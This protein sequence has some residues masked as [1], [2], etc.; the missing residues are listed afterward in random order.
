MKQHPFLRA[1]LA[2]I[3]VPTVFVLVAFSV[4]CVARFVYQVP[5]PI[6]RVIVFPLALIPNA[7]GAWNMLFVALH[8]RRY[9]P[10]GIHGALLPFIIAPTG[11]LIA[12]SL[13]FLATSE[14][15]LVWFGTI[16]IDYSHLAI[17]FPTVLVVYYLVWK[18]LVGFLNELLGVA[19]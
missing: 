16:R 14:Q 15:G 11:F 4:F 2:G 7:F 8:R 17:V 1:Y 12:T 3:A 5:L 19:A 13:G 18:Y 10:L 6:E 9:L